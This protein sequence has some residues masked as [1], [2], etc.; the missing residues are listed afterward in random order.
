MTHPAHHTTPGRVLWR[1]LSGAHL[2]G[3][4]RTDAGWIVPGRAIWTRSGRASRWS[5]R[6][7][8]WRASVRLVA[9]VAATASAAGLRLAPTPTLVALVALAAAGTAAAAWWATRSIRLWRHRRRY[10]APLHAVLAGQLG[11]PRT[12]RPH[13]WLDVPTDYATRD[14]AVIRVAL[15]PDTHWSAELRRTVAGVVADKLGIPDPVASWHTIGREPYATFRPAPHPPAR[16]TYADVAAAIAAA[17]ETAP[18][19]GLAAGNRPVSVDCEADA[20]H[21]LV[22]MASGA[23]KSVLIRT[24]TAQMLARGAQIVVLDA[25]RVSQAWLRSLPGVTY[26]RTAETAHRALIELA[27]E[28]DRR[29]DLVDAAPDDAVDQVDVGP[30]IVLVYEEMNAMQGR[31]SR[32]WAATREKGDPRVSPAVAAFLDIVSMGR[33]GRVNVLAVAQLGTARVM[34]GPDV[35]ESFSNRVLG[36]YTVQAWRMLAGEIWPMP[37]ASSHQGRVQV[38]LGGQATE[39]Q[40]AFLTPAE[41]RELAA[42]GAVTVPAGWATRADAPVT[43]TD[44]APDAPLF[45][46]AEAARQ[47]WCPLGYAALRQAKSRGRKAG[48]WPAGHLVDGVERWTRAELAAALANRPRA[49]DP[50]DAPPA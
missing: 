23:G 16:V 45:T 12:R 8:L 14:G 10:V 21:T 4:P 44:A 7:R 29:Y 49:A 24:V 34:G 40:C 25:K 37:R 18:I 2:D 28:V 30:R 5:H 46:L 33:Q 11:V 42:S 31:L 41:A 3:V 48:D 17:P 1:F 6:P 43:V 26:C 36:R 39:V 22:S 13:D 27:A 35:R 19:I 47:A 38:V 32:Y 50:V 20:P 15:P 9:L